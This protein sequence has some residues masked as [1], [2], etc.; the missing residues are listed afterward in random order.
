MTAARPDKW[1]TQ[2]QLARLRDMMAQWRSARD[3]GLTIP[4]DMQAELESLVE[5]EFCLHLHYALRLS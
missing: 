5:T 4:Q 3:N 1:F 2:E